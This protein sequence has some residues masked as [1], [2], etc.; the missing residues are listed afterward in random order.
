MKEKI[1][2]NGNQEK[3]DNVDK[4]K[5][6]RQK[7]ENKFINMLKNSWKY[8]KKNMFRKHFVLYIISLILF[9]TVF[10]YSL[11]TY[12]AKYF[13]ENVGNVARINKIMS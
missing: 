5:R 4:F 2:L 6:L 11:S 12:D 8:Y 7:K 1:K 9:V 13:L 10:V 3:G